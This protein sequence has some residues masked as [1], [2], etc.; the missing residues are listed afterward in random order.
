M[1]FYQKISILIT[2]KIALSLFLRLTLVS[3]PAKTALRSATQ[4]SIYSKNK[5]TLGELVQR[6]DQSA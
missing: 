6:C 5:G 4:C 1:D 3:T 2:S